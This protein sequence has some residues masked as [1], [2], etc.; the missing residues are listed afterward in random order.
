MLC[1]TGKISG[2]ACSAGSLHEIVNDLVAWSV[3][4]ERWPATLQIVVA[5]VQWWQ[6]VEESLKINLEVALKVNQVPFHH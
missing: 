4:Q 5:N 6:A 2:D 3:P 1:R